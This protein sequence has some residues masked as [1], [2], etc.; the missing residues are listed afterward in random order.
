[1]FAS[2]IEYNPSEYDLHASLPIQENNNKNIRGLGKES[3][4]LKIRKKMSER[5]EFTPIGSKFIGN[6]PVGKS[7][8]CEKKFFIVT[9]TSGDTVCTFKD[10][11]PII[12]F[13]KSLYRGVDDGYSYYFNGILHLRQAYNDTI[14]QLLPPN[15]LIPKYILDFGNLGIRSANDGINPDYNLKDKLVPQSFIETNRFLFIT[16]SKDY[17]CPATAKLGT[18]KYSRLIYDKINKKI[19]PIYIDETP[20]LSKGGN[21]MFPSAPNTNIENDLDVMP[22]RWPFS[23]TSNGHVFS[24]FSGEELLELK[25]QNMPIKNIRKNERIIVIYR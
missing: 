6:N 22:F 24:V 4:P 10:N 23:V 21:M 1:G 15:R 2:L 12:N 16:Y 19:I 7:L 13:S 11:D 9:S 17:E 18:L 20:Y 5:P 3:G 25:D 8:E 14:Y